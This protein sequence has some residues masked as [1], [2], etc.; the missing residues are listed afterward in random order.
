MSKGRNVKRSKCRNVK[1]SKC[2]GLL[3]VISCWLLAIGCWQESDPDRLR[4]TSSQAA[5]PAQ[6]YKAEADVDR[7]LIKKVFF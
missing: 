2:P 5:M 3:L 1:R 7:L 4:S 6:I